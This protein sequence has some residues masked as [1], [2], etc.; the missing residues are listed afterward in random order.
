M[1]LLL[2]TLFIA[3][4]PVMELL[5]LLFV[6]IAVFWYFRNQADKYYDKWFTDLKDLAKYYGYRPEEIAE[7]DMVDW[8][9]FYLAGLTPEESIKEKLSEKPTQE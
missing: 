8:E 2:T 5:L 4:K 9:D 1:I 6:M 7:F 3:V